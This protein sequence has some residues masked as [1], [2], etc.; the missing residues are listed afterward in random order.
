MPSETPLAAHRNASF[1]QIS[2]PPSFDRSIG[3]IL[4]GYGA[5][6]ATRS[7]RDAWFV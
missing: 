3:R 4:P 6:N 1:W 5:A 7:L 2:V